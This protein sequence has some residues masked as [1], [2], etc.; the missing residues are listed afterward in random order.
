MRK[1]VLSAGN[2]IVDQIKTIDHFPKQGNLVNIL[3]E[4][5]GIGGAPH[6]VLVDIAKMQVDI[7]LSV[8]GLVGKDTNGDL[9]QQELEK[10]RID[11][12]NL[13]RSETNT[14]TSYT[15]V[16]TEQQSGGRTFF[17]YRGANAELDIA[18]F[19]DIHEQSKLFHLG[20]L[21]LLDKLD[22]KD[23]VYGIVA[24]RL[25]DMMKKRGYQTSVDVVSE[26]SER[27]MHVVTPCL[28][29]ID[30][31][32]VNEI[33]AGAS[34]GCTI[35]NDGETLNTK[36]LMKAAEILFEK[37]V[38]QLVV[39]H[40]PEGGFAMDKTGEKIFVPS[41][42][43]E[44]KD[45]KSSVGA[46][47]AF[48]AGILYGI[49]EQLSINETIQIANA[50]ALFN[51]TNATTTGGAVDIEKIKKFIPNATKREAIVKL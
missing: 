44:N 39:I 20:Y 30:Y 29:Y 46:G 21:L 34:T 12:T 13:F 6:N 43:I 47:D 5:I 35:R 19:K 28:K 23:E 31:L 2:L 25:L 42:Y 48:C 10:N 38:N 26:Q 50:N 49:H 18:H 4:T 33:E 16:M 36:N 40:F 14:P 9:I 24:A 11:T 27:F 37:G 1:G 32:I 17:H 22:S 15:D 8:A 7:P 3:D 45:I 51:L 41:Y